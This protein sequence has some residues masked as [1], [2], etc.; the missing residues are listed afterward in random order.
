MKIY[1]NGGDIEDENDVSTSGE[2]IYYSVKSGDTIGKIAS[3]NKISIASIKVWNNLKNNT[4]YPGQKL[5]IGI[6]STGTTNREVNTSDTKIHIVKRGET[7][8]GIAEK[9]HVRARD[10]RQ[11]NGLNGSLIRVGQRL[12]IYPKGSN[13][14][15]TKN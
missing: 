15:A 11:W 2:N 6:T 10:I 14:L 9:Y 7:L 4:I 13:K 8:G 12:T 1:S 5:K 3:K